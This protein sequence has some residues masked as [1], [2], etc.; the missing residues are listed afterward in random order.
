MSLKRTSQL[1]NKLAVNN[2]NK[3]VVKSQYA[4]RGAI[5]AKAAEYEEDLKK[6]KHLPFDK[7]LYCNIGNPLQ[8]VNKHITFHRNVLS[9]VTSPNF[10]ENE[11][12]VKSL[13]KDVIERAKKI[14][15]YFDSDS[16]A[17]THSQ[18]LFPV[19]ESVA[20]FIGERDGYPSNPK[21]IFLTNGASPGIQMVL[22]AV[23][24][25]ENDCILIPIPQY[26]LYSASITLLGGSY[27]GYYLNEEENWSTPLS[28]IQSA[29]EEA[30][31][32]GKNVRALAVI[33]PG[34]PTGQI[35]TV[36]NQQE[37]IQF[38][39]EKG[40][41]LLADEVYQ[42]NI[43]GEQPFVSFKKAANDMGSKYSTEKNL[44]LFSY[45][46]LSKGFLGECGR[47]G[48]Y[49]EI[50]N[51]VDEAVV[52]QLYKIAS[53]SLCSNVD[54][55]ILMDLKVNPPKEGDES[56]EQYKKE[57]DDILVSLKK[58]AKILVEKLQK[59]EGVSCSE[60]SGAM[61]AF[62][63]VELPKKVIE[64][65]KEKNI[66]PDLFY[67]MELLKAT[68]IVVVPGSGF[69]QKSGT[70]HFRTTFLPPEDE[71]LEFCN[72]IEKFHNEFMNKY[73]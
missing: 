54:A 58:R 46:T 72:R 20:K 13:P 29:Y 67:C 52:D 70:Y 59:L 14:L 3:Y 1:F 44:E 63:K 2:L 73:A 49:M 71:I 42:E 7:L 53:V 60:V 28:S 8:L 26:P 40:I 17:Y 22:Q 50:S 37:I 30:I 9:L 65:A 10:L 41:I 6:G 62:P 55:Q 36:E 34:N 69:E 51:S 19:R 39:V 4:V 25:D 45:H 5:V 66:A 43:Y 16:G 33:N 21:R 57:R 15:N 23:I 18:G 68:G 32:K 38:C 61:Y 35:L 27:S 64:L 56:Y 24:R 31:K 47:R 11:E 48:G 12:L